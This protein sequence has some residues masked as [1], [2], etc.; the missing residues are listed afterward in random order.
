MVSIRIRHS[1]YQNKV[2]PLVQKGGS[3][4]N[5]LAA[6]PHKNIQHAG[7]SKSA[8]T[9]SEIELDRD[10]H[11]PVYEIEFETKEAE[12]EYEIDAYTGKVA[13]FG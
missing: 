6:P 3:R 7:V 9:E 2:A 12:Y 10:D 1:K 5:G 13:N 11:K 8:I 4:H